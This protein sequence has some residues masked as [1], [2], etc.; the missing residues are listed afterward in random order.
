M[1][2]ETTN[3][4]YSV[5]DATIVSKYSADGKRLFVQWAFESEV[6]GTAGS[7]RYGNKYENEAYGE[8][9]CTKCK[10]RRIILNEIYFFSI[11]TSFPKILS[12]FSNKV[13]IRERINILD[14]RRILWFFYSYEAF[15]FV[16]FI[17]RNFHILF[18]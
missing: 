3:P 10:L 13:I 8:F 16:L 7:V 1:I 15:L 9:C 4:T 17:F 11:F 6:A 2:G 12:C 18:F 5:E 14:V